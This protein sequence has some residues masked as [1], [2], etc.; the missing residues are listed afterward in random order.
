MH[1]INFPNNPQKGD[2]FHNWQWDGEKWISI[3]FSGWAPLHSPHF[4][5]HPTA[6]TPNVRS[7][8]GS[9]ATTAWVRKWIEDGIAG[10]ASFND[11]TGNVELRWD[12]V[13]DVG[14]APIHSP[15]FTGTPTAFPPPSFD[16][17]HRLATTSWVGFRLD[18]ITDHM[19]RSWNGREGDVVL[20]WEDVEHVGGAPI[21]SPEFEGQPSTPT[22]FFDS[23]DFSIANTH[24]VQERLEEIRALI[25][26]EID[27]SRRNSVLS[28]NGRRGHVKFLLADLLAAGGAPL[29]SPH[30]TGFPR[31]PTPQAG[32][33]STRVATTEFVRSAIEKNLPERGPP[34]ERG[35][36]GL[37]GRGFQILG[38]VP[39]FFQLPLHGNL[40]GDVR[41]V[42]ATGIGYVWTCEARVSGFVGFGGVITPPPRPPGPPVVP[43][44]CHWSPIGFLRLPGPPGIQGP[45]GPTGPP[46]L[47]GP[48]GP[49][50]TVGATGAQGPTGATGPQG[51]QG[52]S[53]LGM[54]ILGTIGYPGPPVFDGVNPNDTWIDSIDEAWVWN[55]VEWISVGPLQGP[56][57]PEGP[58]GAMGADG[59][60]GPEGPPGDQGP[61]GPR[62][63]DG[64]D[65]ATGPQGPPGGVGPIGPIG[66]AGPQGDIGPTGSTGATGAT[67]A[68]GPQGPT[69]PEGPAGAT[70]QTG[71]QGPPGPPLGAAVGPVPPANP[72]NGDLWYNTASHQTFVWNGADWVIS[73]DLFTATISGIVPMSGGGQ[74]NFLRADGTW[75]YPLAPQP[76]GTVLANLGSPQPPYPVTLAALTAALT[77]F[78]SA[79]GVGVVPPFYSANP[80]RYLLRADGTWGSPIAVTRVFTTSGTYVPT[81]GTL[82]AIVE[83]W[84][85]GGGG[86]W[87]VTGS[88]NVLAGGGGGSG[89]YSRSLLSIAEIGAGQTVTVGAGGGNAGNGGQTSFGSL[90][91]AG[92]G[93]AGGTNDGVSTFGQSGGGGAQGIVPSGGMAIAGS[94]GAQGTVV[95]FIQNN[96]NRMVASGGSGGGNGAAA[97]FA[98]V[99]VS[100]NGGNAN[101]IGGGSGGASVFDG[102]GSGAGNGGNGGPGLVFVTEFIF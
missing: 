75:S 92:G 36:Q 76:S 77:I 99:N 102:S 79:N 21:R 91:T 100:V 22:P 71:P 39:T 5:G 17:S 10:V 56:I 6:P 64:M 4:T 61:E 13:E 53:G 98:G 18:E 3:G 20:L 72:V 49:Q 40:P 1:G 93:L 90:I 69:G 57:G 32:D 73:I 34:G 15:Q 78:P 68:T 2:V 94:P 59:L 66:P 38:S 14:G 28:W 43:V 74:Q 51:P 87:V 37:T 63:A 82:Y 80:Q 89:A 11:R 29:H 67:G 46:G 9:L 12:D 44:P 30:F 101:R 50:G 16:F 60:P 62:G 8:D 31:A 96:A 19:V 88:T 86:G 25:D 41:I 70:G 48:R 81:V 97:S 52:P 54:N 42:E 84:G 27:E 45:P 47:Q 7:N 24:W 58:A 95:T 23:D 65:G 55:G 33:A 85:A 26:R 35:P 83:C